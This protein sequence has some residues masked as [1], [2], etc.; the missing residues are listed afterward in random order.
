VAYRTVSRSEGEALAARLDCAYFETSAAE[1]LSSVTTAFGR[2]LGDVIRLRDRQT[3]QVNIL[4]RWAPCTLICT[5]S[6]RSISGR[7]GHLLVVTFL[8]LQNK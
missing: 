4:D 3:L 6:A 2:V 7:D 1:D 5:S 8:T